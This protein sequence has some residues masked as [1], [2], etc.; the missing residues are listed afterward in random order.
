VLVGRADTVAPASSC[1]AMKNALPA[2]AVP[3]LDLVVYPRA[4]HTFDMPLPDR[5]ILGMRLGYDAGAAADA[6]QRAVA[7]LAAY[8]SSGPL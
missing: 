8:V 3:A 2:G 5:T 4:P 1:E 6:R 7:F